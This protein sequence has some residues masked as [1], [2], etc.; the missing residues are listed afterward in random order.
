[1][2]LN[3]LRSVVTVMLFIV[4]IGIVIWA[5]SQR[6]REAFDSAAQL[7]L[8]DDE[9]VTDSAARRSTGAKQ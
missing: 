1:M 2:E 7:P 9:S 4:F 3:E 8:I 6:R 5:W